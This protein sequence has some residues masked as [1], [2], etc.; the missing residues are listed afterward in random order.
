[1]MLRVAQI[2]E[3]LEEHFPS[4]LQESYDNCGLQVGDPEGIA[5]GVLCCVDITEAV[6]QEAVERGCNVV[7]AHHPLLFKGLKRLGTSS[8]IER[9]VRFA[10]KHDLAIY[11]AHTSADNAAEGLHWRLAQDFGLLQPRILLPQT[12]RLLE[13]TVYVPEAA[14]AAVA[15]A[16][17]AAGA[18]RV[19]SYDSCSY[20]SS[21]QGSFRPLAGAQPYVG[22]LGALHYEQE[23]RLSMVLPSHL[24]A[25]VEAALLAAH[26]YEV[27]AYSFTQLLDTRG[28][29]G[30]G[31]V[32][33]LPQPVA[34][35]DFLAEVKRY[36]ATE[37]LR[38]SRAEATRLIQRVAICGGAGAFLWPEARRAGADILITGEAKYNDYFDC[39]SAPILATVGHYES[40]RISAQLFTELLSQKLAT[41]A[42]Y[43]SEI[44]SN[45][46]NSVIAL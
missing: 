42:V 18:G 5:T 11:A 28:S 27:P 6:L 13:L 3:L 7:I 12:D 41:F 4:S 46:I 22:E 43:Q 30:A 24:S 8:Y 20:R 14:T 9:C 34:L 31:I 2:W 39:E 1:M 32:G 33:E 26:P 35:G 16:L 23:D 37:Q 29:T 45:P 21:G 44:D 38:Y 25:R 40:E 36:F 10:L 17:W 19:G 15:E